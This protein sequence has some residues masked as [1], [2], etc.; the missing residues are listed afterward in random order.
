MIGW[1]NIGNKEVREST[2][3]NTEVRNLFQKWVR[4]CFKLNITMWCF[5][6]ENRDMM[7]G[8][9]KI[10]K[11]VSCMRYQFEASDYMSTYILSYEKCV[12]NCSAGVK[13]F[14]AWGGICEIGKFRIHTLHSGVYA[15]HTYILLLHLHQYIHYTI[16]YYY[17][18]YT[19]TYTAPMI[20]IQ[21]HI[22]TTTLHGNK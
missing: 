13:M 12:G 20:Q 11:C 19:D 10:Q 3:E 2:K 9:Q 17:Y 22:T 15:V 8:I 16:T 1:L 5:E 4:C 6:N 14:M 7:N 21:V 18:M